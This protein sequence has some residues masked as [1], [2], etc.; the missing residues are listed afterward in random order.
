MHVPVGGAQRR[1]CAHS[2]KGRTQCVCSGCPDTPLH[3]QGFA[4]THGLTPAG[5]NEG[6]DSELPLN[7][8]TRDKGDREDNQEADEEQEEETQSGDEE[9]EECGGHRKRRG[10]RVGEVLLQKPVDG[11]AEGVVVGS[12]RSW[13]PSLYH[14]HPWG[15]VRTSGGTNHVC[16]ILKCEDPPPLPP[17]NI[18]VVC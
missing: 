11:V 3:V 6:E 15:L 16:S 7:Q 1:P 14:P 13:P 17:A 8:K 9:E 10:G 12:R 2:G 5:T 18:G 4:P